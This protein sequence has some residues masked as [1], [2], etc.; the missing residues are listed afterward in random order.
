MWKD[1][2][3]E[4]ERGRLKS[5]ARASKLCMSLPEIM[6]SKACLSNGRWW[7]YLLCL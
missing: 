5:G 1:R 2:E 7:G 4:R 6:A 3:G